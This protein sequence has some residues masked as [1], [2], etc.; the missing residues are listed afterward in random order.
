MNDLS[1]AV[2][3]SLALER[4]V[5][6]PI[7]GGY[8]G[9]YY[10]SSAGRIF[11]VISARCLAQPPNENGYRRV[12]LYSGGHPSIPKVWKVA[13]LILLTFEGP[14]PLGMECDHGLKGKGCDEQD[15]LQY[16]T[17]PRNKELFRERGGVQ[18]V[19]RGTDNPRAKL[20]ADQVQDIRRAWDSGDLSQRKLAARYNVSRPIIR[21]I[22]T[23][24]SYKSVT[25]DFSIAV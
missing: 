11:S 16:V 15:N 10:A 8:Q 13:A 12:C 19:H 22:L 3:L 5:W 25:N 2:P 20:T 9:R 1:S 4:E 6:K 18:R 24:K 17:P 14:R 23:G 21:R 7:P